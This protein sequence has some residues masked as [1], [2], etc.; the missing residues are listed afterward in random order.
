MKDF[1]EIREVVEFCKGL[2]S[3]PD[4]RE[5]LDHW[6]EVDFE[7]SGVRFIHEDDIDEIWTE[8]LIDMIKDCY[9]LSDSEIPS[10]IEIDW[11][12]TAENCK[13]DGMGH[14]FNSYDGGEDEVL[15]YHVFDNH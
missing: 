4:A 14:H 1:S 6:G 9:P 8:S 10:F 2:F 7:V 13:V 12:A 5:V 3:E 11:D 15:S